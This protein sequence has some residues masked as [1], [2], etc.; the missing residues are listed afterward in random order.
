MG[1][2]RVRVDDGADVVA[3]ADV[4]EGRDA[5]AEVPVWWFCEF[6]DGGGD[7]GWCWNWWTYGAFQ[8]IGFRPI[9]FTLISTSSS[10]CRLGVSCLGVRA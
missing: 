2:G 8:S 7:N 10:K 9:A 1:R 4:G 3:A 6:G 5:K